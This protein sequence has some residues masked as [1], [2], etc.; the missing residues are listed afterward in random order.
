MNGAGI[1]VGMGQNN[2]RIKT[3]SGEKMSL[4]MGKDSY[5]L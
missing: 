3:S 1:K 2:T 4:E 5:R